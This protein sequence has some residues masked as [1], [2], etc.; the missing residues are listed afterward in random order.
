MQSPSFWTQIPPF[1]TQKTHR[2]EIATFAGLLDV[3]GVYARNSLVTT[4]D[5]SGK[6]ALVQDLQNSSVLRD[7]N[8]S[9][10]MQ[11]SRF[12]TTLHHFHTSSASS[13][14]YPTDGLACQNS[15]FLIQKSSFLIQKSSFWIHNF[16][17]LM[18]NCSFWMPKFIIFHTSHFVTAFLRLPPISPSSLPVRDLLY[19]QPFERSINRRHEYTERDLSI[20]GMYIQ[21]EI[22]QSPA[23]IYRERPINRR[24][25]CAKQAAS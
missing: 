1:W 6:L 19:L 20:A 25:V 16:S 17:V 5:H 24:H 7:K 18:Q 23:C 22:Y 3:L 2:F 21:R 12:N 9:V 14:K 4:V 11:N 15:S 10:L 13:G 8:S